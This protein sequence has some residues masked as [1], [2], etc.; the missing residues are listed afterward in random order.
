M[1]QLKDD[2]FKRITVT[3]DS[4]NHGMVFLLDWSGSMLDNINDTIKQVITL[5]LFCQRTQIPYE[6]YAF[7]NGFPSRKGEY[8]YRNIAYPGDNYKGFAYQQFNLLQFFTHKMT[9]S[10]FNKMCEYLM[11]NPWHWSR[12]MN[13][14][15]TPLNEALLY[16][17]DYLG[18]F[19]KANSVD[20]LTF[21]TL[22]D[23]EGG[24]LY[25][26]S[27]NRSLRGAY[28][29]YSNGEYKRFKVIHY[30]QDNVTRKQYKLNEDSGQQTRTLLAL[31]KDRYSAKT[32]GFYIGRNS[33]RDLA[34]FVR[35]NMLSTSGAEEV[36]MVHNL[37]TEIRKN[38]FAYL[39]NCGRDELYLLPQS[40]MQIKDSD[41]EV[42]AEMNSR[43]IAKA[44]NKFL[45]VKKTNRILLNRF[46]GQIS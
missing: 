22:T 35:N 46:V 41:L 25:S 7:T 17:A 14:N 15:S 5:C 33:R 20:K 31:I 28:N 39:T 12:A 43:Q 34:W 3:K 19:K 23:G 9:Q 27:N 24:S 11:S 40:K 4:K 2:L 16:I 26:G 37:Q 8:A 10:E 32:I 36:A 18:A 44:F 38:D 45:D 13:M 21:I 42:S 1:Y 6:V 30:L 29:D